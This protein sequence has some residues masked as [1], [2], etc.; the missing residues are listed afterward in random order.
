MPPYTQCDTQHQ[1]SPGPSS[2]HHYNP[3]DSWLW[4][5]PSSA[6]SRQPSGD[7]FCCQGAGPGWPVTNVGMCSTQRSAWWRQVSEA[8]FIFLLL[9]YFCFIA[10]LDIYS[11]FIFVS[12]HLFRTYRK[13]TFLATL[14]WMYLVNITNQLFVWLIINNF[15]S[16]SAKSS[17]ANVFHCFLL[18]TVSGVVC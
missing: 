10:Y 6:P 8:K 9:I 13:F 4:S 18:V 15:Y 17:N 14:A 16:A 12:L 1:P 2:P 3:P 11:L 5:G 7:R